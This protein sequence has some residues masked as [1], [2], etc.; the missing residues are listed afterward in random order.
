ME[1]LSRVREVNAT[2][3]HTAP[4]AAWKEG[5]KKVIAFHHTYIPEEIIHAA[6]LLPI[7]ISGTTGPVSMKDANGYLYVNSCTF[8]RSSLQLVLEKRYDFLD[9]YV[10]EGNC[11]CSKRLADVWDH[12]HLT[13]FF[14]ILA[15]P[16]K[17]TPSAQKVFCE[18]NLA[19]KRS[20]EEHFGVSITDDALWESVRVYN[21]TRQLLQRLYETRKSDSPAI[22]GSEILEVMNAG[23]KMPREEFNDILAELVDEAECSARGVKAKFRL[24][25]IG[26]VF[27]N[28]DF[29]K[30]IE[31]MG[32]Q[33]VVED[34]HSGVRY[35][36]G[37]VDTQSGLD[38]MM[39]ISQRYLK[40]L[41]SARMVPEE[42]RFDRLI[43]L[44]REYKVQ[45]IVS[46]VL[47]F[48]FP[49]GSEQP[50]LKKAYESQGF[51]V[52]ELDAEYGTASTGMVRTRLQAFLEMLEA[53]S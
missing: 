9:G 51:P 49:Y 7:A 24:M 13:P 47:R 12:H 43:N 1:A 27:V 2:F 31:D 33:V 50:F 4:I 8:C 14:H 3:P 44:A 40:A 15:A 34:H 6:G 41:P 48:C 10:A 29:M 23:L 26:S 21:V 20:L 25:L 28:P 11:D 38:P 52:L 32:G 35:W 39:A 37:L 45:G 19:L 30:A 16:R 18:E 42:D 36:E 53:R 22:T 46:S 5:G 17:V